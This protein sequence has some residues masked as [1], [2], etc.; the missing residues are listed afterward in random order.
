MRGYRCVL[1]MGL[2]SLAL[3]ATLSGAVP[4]G[5]QGVSSEETSRSVRRMLERLP[6]YGVFAVRRA[7]YSA[8]A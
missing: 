7:N 1:R 2:L 6:Y 4:G 5:M 3:L 8:L